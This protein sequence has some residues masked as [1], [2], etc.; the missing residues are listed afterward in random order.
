MHVR[1]ATSL[2][3]L[4]SWLASGV[5]GALTVNFDSDDSIKSAASTAAYGLVGYYTG[6]NSGDVAG[7]LPDPYYWW[8]AGAMFLSL[9]EYWAVTGDSTYNSIT[10]QALNHQRG[11]DDDFMP[12]NQSKAEGNDDQGFWAMAAMEAA[13]TN[14]QNP[15][16]SEAGW[17]A[18]VQAVYNEYVDRWAEANGTCGGGLRWQIFTFNNGYNYKNSVSN[19]CFFNIAARLARYT[20]NDS[21]ADWADRV[22]E[23]QMGVGFIRARDWA[24]LDGA[25]NA[26][27]ENC[28]EI[29][30][31]QFTYNAGLFLHGAAVMYNT[32]TGSAQQTWKTRVQ[33]LLTSVKS[34]FFKNGVMWEPS[35]E[36]SSAGCNTDQQSFKGHLAR[37]LA[38]TA[39]LA[40]FTADTITPLLQ[41]TATAVAE[42]CDGTAA[43]GYKGTSGTACGFSWLKAAAWDGNSGVGEQMNALN[44]IVATLAQPDPLTKDSGGSSTGDPDAGNSDSDKL[45]TL[46]PI[47]AGDRAGAGILTLLALGG[48]LGG[49]YFVTV[50]E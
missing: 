34:T 30:A 28:T 33:G 37:W 8:E 39:V 29:N 44:A 47:T 18:L 41:S 5:A 16:S 45:E 3:G 21:Y 32:T 11:D 36:T 48:L 25:G 17:L 19:G 26:D 43:S 1:L 9:I 15:P 6:N 24:V 10:Y 14:F 35:C 7:N 27:D 49:S 40:G 4:S 20:G 38:Q 22:F 12:A 46:A 23:W 2:L 42:Q 50:G 31:A 13:E